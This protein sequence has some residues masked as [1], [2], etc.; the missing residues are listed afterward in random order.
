MTLPGDMV[1]FA[2]NVKNK[3]GYLELEDMREA[4]H[5]YQ[6]ADAVQTVDVHRVWWGDEDR[7]AGKPAL[8]IQRLPNEMVHNFDRL[9]EKYWGDP[10]QIPN[11]DGS[12]TTDPNWVAPTDEDLFHPFEEMEWLYVLCDG[13]LLYAAKWHDFYGPDTL[14]EFERKE[15]LERMLQDLKQKK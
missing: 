4:W 6:L 15:R 8:V 12:V 13:T 5:P 9:I 11:D 10:D 3:F 1:S 7:F 14:E 2:R